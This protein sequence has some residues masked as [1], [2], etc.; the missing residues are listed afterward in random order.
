M[1]TI[2][3]HPD[4]DE[5]P[6]ASDDHIPVLLYKC[7]DRMRHAYIGNSVMDTLRRFPVAPSATSLDFLSI[8]LAVTAADTFVNRDIAP[9]RWCRRLSVKVA[10]YDPNVWMPVVPKLETA[11][12][13]LSGDDWSIELLHG[14]LPPQVPFSNASTKKVALRED[15]DCVCLFSGGLDSTIGVLDLVAKGRRP[16]LVSHAYNKDSTIQESVLRGIDVG[17]QRLGVNLYPANLYGRNSDITMRAR[18]FNFLA[19]GVLASSLVRKVTGASSLDLIIPENGFIAI[20]PP[21]TPRRVGSLSTRTT[22]PYFL[23]HMQQLL[24]TVGEPVQIVNPYEFKT[25]GEMFLECGQRTV[26]ARVASETMSCSNWKRKGH[27]CGRCVPCL[28]RRASFAKARVTDSSPYETDDLAWGDAS[29]KWDDLIAVTAAVRRVSGLGHRSFAA[30]SGPLPSDPALRA[31]YDS[32][33]RRG[34][35]EIARFLRPLGLL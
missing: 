18:S 27:A 11:L 33:V 20:N 29:R 35:D 13:F 9:D 19:L 4:I 1:T 2:F 16:V 21:L 25:K 22:H 30:K 28:I 7:G 10:L 34:L 24:N 8:A 3:C 17:L 14:G 32:V 23:S 31:R 26:L 12:R 6:L 15:S 5:L